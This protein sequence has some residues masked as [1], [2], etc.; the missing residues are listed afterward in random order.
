MDTDFSQQTLE[1]M[2]QAVWYNRWTLNKFKKYL[3]GNILEVGCGIGNFT[4]SLKEYGD[5]Y[6]IDINEN[7]IK[8]VRKQIGEQAGFGDI[9][10]DKYFF[11]DKLFDTI[12]CINVLEHIKKDG[13]ALKNLYKL[14]KESGHL[15]LLVPVHPFLFCEIDKSIGHFRRYVKDQL[16]EKL[17]DFGFKILSSR[18]LNFLGAIGWYVSGKI[19]R[20]NKINEKK[21]KIFNLVAP[22]VLPFE[23]IIEPPSGTS[24]LLIAKKSL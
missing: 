12:V 14:L 18:K 8:E 24:I 22:L 16:I 21:I 23:D 3:K 10:K 19:F 7:Y 11:G 17:N 2:S 4:K 13:Q 9:E 15:I 5:V 20:E 6:A 1:S